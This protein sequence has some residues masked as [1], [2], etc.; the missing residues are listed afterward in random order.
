ML[1]AYNKM[2]KL[3]SQVLC[4][5]VLPVLVGCVTSNPSVEPAESLATES[6]VV[7]VL[8]ASEQPGD[9][10]ATEAEDSSVEDVS[11]EPVVQAAPASAAPETATPSPVSLVKQ[12][13]GQLETQQAM[14][15]CAADNYKVA[16]KE[17]NEV[18]QQVRQGLEDEFAKKQL[19]DAEGR[20]ITFRDAQCAFESSYLEGGSMAPLIQSSCLEQITDNRTA[21]LKQTPGPGINFVT[22]DTQLNQVYGAV[23]S[24]TQED[25][26]KALIDVQLNWLDYRDA[27]CEYESSLPSGLNIENCLASLTETRVWQLQAIRN[28]WSF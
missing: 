5:S 19:T 15:Q 10:A 17:L 18:Y 6:E 2:Q 22:A 14:N 12:D 28:S 4:L 21:E 13:C 23:K 26:T 25:Q 24:L 9:S 16:D 3:I 7:D 20:W 1:G 27:H 11:S 8:S